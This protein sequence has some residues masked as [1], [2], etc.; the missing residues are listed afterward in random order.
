MIIERC[1]S[2]TIRDQDFRALENFIEQQRSSHPAYGNMTRTEPAGFLFNIAHRRRWTE[3]EGE[4]SILKDDGQIIGVS[5]VERSALHDRLSIGGIRMWIAKKFRNRPLLD[6]RN[7]FASKL[8]LASNL[9]WSQAHGMW[10]MMVTFND[11]NKTIFEG[12]KRK[13][14]RRAVI[15]DPSDWWTDGQIIEGTLCIRHTDQWCVLKPIE[16]PGCRTIRDKLNEV[17][18]NPCPG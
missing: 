9:H 5:A 3:A 15:G 2:D 4:I 6:D 8:L 11:Y 18:T 1:H 12:I 14:A 13:A 10:A 7:S 16:L 17:K